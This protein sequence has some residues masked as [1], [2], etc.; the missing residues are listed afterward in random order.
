MNN[1]VE[2]CINVQTACLIERACEIINKF[3]IK[4]GKT[5]QAMMSSISWCLKSFLLSSVTPASVMM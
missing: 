3:Q 2:S 5:L 1:C 4:K